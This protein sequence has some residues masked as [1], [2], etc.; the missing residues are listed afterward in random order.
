MTMRFPPKILITISFKFRV[1]GRAATPQNHLISHMGM[2]VL[3]SMNGPITLGRLTTVTFRSLHIACAESLKGKCQMLRS[4]MTYDN[5]GKIIVDACRK[6]KIKHQFSC[7]DY[8]NKSLSFCLCIGSTQ[9]RT[10]NTVTK[11]FIIR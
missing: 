1:T 11:F 10:S 4:E 6:Q 5:C 3:L 2:S 9:V 8:D 7:P